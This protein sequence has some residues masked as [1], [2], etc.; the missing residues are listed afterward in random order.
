MSAEEV[1]GWGEPTAVTLRLKGTHEFLPI[2][3]T[4]EEIKNASNVV[5]KYAIWHKYT[6]AEGTEF[7]QVSIFYVK[8]NNA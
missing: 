6:P 1:A 3:F 2:E 8:D 7:D 5:T 4:V